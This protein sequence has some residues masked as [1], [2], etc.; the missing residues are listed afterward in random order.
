[1]FFGFG[2]KRPEGLP[3][4]RWVDIKYLNHLENALSHLRYPEYADKYQSWQ[5]LNKL[6]S[7]YNHIIKSTVSTLVGA[8]ERH[9]KHDYPSFSDAVLH[10]H[11]QVPDSYH[12]KNIFDF[13]FRSYIDY[14]ID[15][16]RT[17]FD[18]LEIVSNDVTKIHKIVFKGSNYLGDG[19][20]GIDEQVFVQASGKEK[21]DAKKMGKTLEIICKE[22]D[23]L[24]SFSNLQDKTQEIYNV[25]VKFR[26]QLE[27]LTK[28]IDAGYTIKGS[29]SFGF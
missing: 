1:M 8:I 14:I 25:R 17:D 22:P 15:K 12:S 13:I 28:D 27:S 21:L 23:T 3:Q 6:V 2:F 5:E 7:E 20:W 11:E 18:K 26:K 4:I 16:V 9:M 19:I 29:C 10:P 24:K